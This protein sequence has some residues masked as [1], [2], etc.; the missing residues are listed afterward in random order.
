MTRDYQRQ[1]FRHPSDI[2][3]H[4]EVDARSLDAA[5]TNISRGGLALVSDR[6]PALDSVV[7]ISVPALGNQVTI[8]GKVAWCR[9]DHDHFLVGIRFLDSDSAFLARMISQI[10]HIEQYRQQ[11]RKR[12][13]RRL[14]SEQAAAEWIQHYAKDFPNATPNNGKN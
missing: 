11:V 6:K 3:L 4:L 14:T 12:E 10:H 5:L 2:P 7:L 1:F 8:K 9:S 13:G